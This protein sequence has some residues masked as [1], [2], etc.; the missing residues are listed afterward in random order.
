MIR[1]VYYLCYSDIKEKT[2]LVF[3]AELEPDI[4]SPG[5]WTVAIKRQERFAESF[6]FDAVNDNQ[7]ISTKL[8]RVNRSVYVVDTE[9]HGKFF[10]RINHIFYRY[11]N[12][13]GNS[14]LIE[15]SDRL[16]QLTSMDI[17]KLERT[18]EKGFFFVGKVDSNLE[19]RR[20][21]F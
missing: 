19:N 2:G 21:S 14:N 17:Q 9:K 20:K 8:V 7:I 13:V 3:P 11:E 4:Y 10:F 5:I 15:Q 6:E 16:Y 18:C 12:Y 1:N